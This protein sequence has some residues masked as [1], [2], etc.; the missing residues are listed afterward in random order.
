[1]NNIFK[2]SS[3]NYQVGDIISGFDLYRIKSGLVVNTILKMKKEEKKIEIKEHESIVDIAVAINP[4]CAKIL[5]VIADDED[6]ILESEEE[7]M[8]LEEAEVISV[9]MDYCLEEIMGWGNSSFI[10]GNP[11]R[12]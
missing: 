3:R 2:V 6:Y 9:T 4:F 12:K 8:E 1:M 10:K 5:K 11:I 7:L